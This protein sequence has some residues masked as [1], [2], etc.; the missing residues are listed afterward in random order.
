M[1]TGL[2]PNKASGKV[3]TPKTAAESTTG[4]RMNFLSGDP[5]IEI[6]NF[7]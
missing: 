7:Q 4:V 6:D 5:D 2:E 1:V 3:S